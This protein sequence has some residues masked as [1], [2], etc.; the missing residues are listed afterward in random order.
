ME[1]IVS[2]YDCSISID[3]GNRCHCTHSASRAGQMLPKSTYFALFAG[4]AAK[5]ACNLLVY[6]GKLRKNIL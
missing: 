4:I 1:R 6:A 5:T 2:H 3:S